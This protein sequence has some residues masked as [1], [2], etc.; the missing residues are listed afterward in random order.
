[1]PVAYCGHNI[2]LGWAVLHMHPSRTYDPIGFS[3]QD[4]PLLRPG[5]HIRAPGLY[6]LL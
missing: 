5:R 3:H 4:F 2:D 6:S 1:M